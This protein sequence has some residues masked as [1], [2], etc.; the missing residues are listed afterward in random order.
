MLLLALELKLLEV[1]KHRLKLVVLVNVGE[2]LTS[3]VETN[4]FVGVVLGRSHAL[5]EPE[6]R[7]RKQFSRV[8]IRNT[9]VSEVLLD[10]YTDF[11]VPNTVTH[12]QVLR[13]LLVLFGGILNHI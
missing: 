10:H 11:S 3:K 8:L 9:V 1:L 13:V 7:T 6:D 2:Q 4:E 12:Q 5:G